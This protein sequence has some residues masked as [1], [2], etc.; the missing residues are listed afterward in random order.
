MS[1][2]YA[3]TSAERAEVA[4]EKQS[5]RLFAILSRPE[6]VFKCRINQVF[7]THD[8]V[9]AF[10]YD[11]VTLG[12]AAAVAYGMTVYLGSA[13]G[14]WNRGITHVRKTPAGGM[15]F[16]GEGSECA[17]ANDL[18]VTVVNDWGIWAEHFRM[19]TAGTYYMRHDI[20]Y[21][22]Q[23]ASPDPVVNIGPDRAKPYTGSPVTFYFDAARSWVISGA[24]AS[25]VWSAPGSSSIRTATDSGAPS[26]NRGEITFPAPGR[27]IVSCKITTNTGANRTAYREVYVYNADMLT[28]IES[29]ESL[30]GSQSA[31]GWEAAITLATSLPASLPERAKLLIVAEERFGGVAK[32]LGPVTDAENV[33]FIG[34]TT[35]ETLQTDEYKGKISIRAATA[36]YWLNRIEAF[37]AYLVNVGTRAPARWTEMTNGLS[38]DKM[39][40]HLVAWRSTLN[41]AV[42]F[43]RTGDTRFASEINP[44]QGKLWNQMRVMANETIRAL[45]GCNRYGQF[46]AMLDPQLLTASERGG[47][48]TVCALG[49]DDYQEVN[50]TRQTVASV[51]RVELSGMAIDVNNQAVTYRSLAPGHVFGRH[52]SVLTV[53]RLLL[54]GQAAANSLAALHYAKGNLPFTLELSGLHNNRFFDPFPGMYANLAIEAD[55]NWRGFSYA[56]AALVTGVTHKHDKDKGVFSVNLTLEPAT[57]EGPS[58]NGDVP[59]APGTDDWSPP[60][61]PPI[62]L[63]PLP[64]LPPDVSLTGVPRYAV[65]LLAHNRTYKEQLWW[66][67]TFD[68]DKP[69]W[70][71]LNNGLPTDTKG[72]IWTLTG[73]QAGRLYF[74]TAKRIYT[75][76]LGGVPRLL[77]DESY[78]TPLYPTGSSFPYDVFALGADPYA[79]DSIAVIAG[80]P[81]PGYY[82]FHVGS[83][84]GL[85]VARD[86]PNPEAQRG[87]LSAFNNAWLYTGQH[88]Y[89]ASLRVLRLS[90]NG[91]DLQYQ[92][93]Y[94][95]G[96]FVDCF[97]ARAGGLLGGFGDTIFIP[98]RNS[99]FVGG[100]EVETALPARD[101]ISIA[102]T[103]DGLQCM[104]QVDGGYGA[105]LMQSLD[106]GNSWAALPAYRPINS[107]ITAL[108]NFGVGKFVA[109][110][111]AMS[112]EPSSISVTVNGGVTFL[113]RTGNLRDYVSPFFPAQIMVFP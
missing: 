62:T 80:K 10:A 48:P 75:F 94:S 25:C 70:R 58:T 91:A 30:S 88:G 76:D 66:T 49:E 110:S 101:F 69:I 28:E 85:S 83:R 51:S 107:T 92:F 72:S 89:S 4:S 23:H 104:A 14:G 113:D 18:Y 41:N 74:A 65:L 40:W 27:Y 15:F 6:P 86:M 90:G 26:A 39:L 60:S 21:S 56:G 61:F 96:S 67:D 78:F 45:L 54:G 43:Y 108:A 79:A 5:S 37:P 8:K 103:A 47:I 35:E 44:P 64:P 95:D 98:A 111:Y 59:T 46:Y 22:N 73:N 3:M 13:D 77:A 11:T 109:A 34:W 7:T 9:Y 63:P 93:S 24:L 19:N 106:G 1:V 2:H 71:S 12:S 105:R 50:L 31:G 102:A 32:S 82:R 112:G 87:S 52:G 97:H 16:V 57:V 84:A 53:D 42:D 99:K 81:Y 38:V 17:Y 100:G 20:P 55:S 68:Q 33:V 29:L 36:H